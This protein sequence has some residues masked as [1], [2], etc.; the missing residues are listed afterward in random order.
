MLSWEAIDGSNRVDVFEINAGGND[1]YHGTFDGTKWTESAKLAGGGGWD[2]ICGV[3]H[4]KAGQ[5]PAPYEVE[6]FLVVGIA[7]NGG[8]AGAWYDLNNNLLGGQIWPLGVGN[9]KL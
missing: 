9:Y 3:R 6:H 2:R 8:M 5:M 7:I 4:Y 1:L